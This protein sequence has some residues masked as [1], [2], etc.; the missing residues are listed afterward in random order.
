VNGRLDSFRRA[1][2]LIREAAAPGLAR[3]SANV[4]LLILGSAAVGVLTQVAL[5]RSLG[6]AEYGRY[7][8]A[9]SWALIIAA[10]TMAGLD[11]SI[12]RFAPRYIDHG[13][14][15][16]LRRFTLFIAWVQV[17]TIALSAAVV[18]FTP[19]KDFALSGLRGTGVMWLIIYIGSTAVVG[20]FSA[21]FIAF[22][23]F[24]FSQLYQSFL[25]PAFLIGTILVVALIGHR[26][27]DA[28][29]ALVA[30]AVTSLA[31][32]V[33]L[34]VHVGMKV[35]STGQGGAA[36]FEPKRWL[37]FTGWAQAGSLA[38][39]CTFHVPVILLGAL[40][41][42]TE[43]AFYAV[44]VRVASLVTFGLSAVGTV[45]APMISSAH[46]RRDWRTISQVARLA[47]RLATGIALCAVALFA[48]AGSQVMALF[49]HAFG[50][51]YLPLLVLLGG[52]LVNAVTGVNVILLSMT[53]R[54]RFAVQALLA[55][56]AVNIA[57]SYVLVYH[58]GALGAAIGAFA[59][60]AVSNV[61]M[62]LKI[63]RELGIDST[64]IG[65]RSR[66]EERP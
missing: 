65:L 56:A 66:S 46:A 58:Y 14:G 22:R 35:R 52:A 34:L 24:G 40:S 51:A 25:R 5:T 39:Q 59:G 30:T 47:A 1:F 2:R 8:V 17:A 28:N 55:G 37:G 57:L 42:P 3:D 54:P 29:F 44:A 63:H 19:V 26:R 21:F 48:I 60:I 43:A 27:I 53:D 13:E 12:L 23:Q 49:G 61:L 9:I 36:V 31:G 10:P 64:V 11:A 20:S 32:L 18:L 50:G 38:Q 33:L 4:F 16:Q 45:S 6:A 7:A 15:A 41:T 62:V